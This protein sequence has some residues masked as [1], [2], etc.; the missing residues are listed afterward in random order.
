MFTKKRLHL[1]NHN[2]D[3]NTSIAASDAADEI[4]AIACKDSHLLDIAAAN[5]RSIASQDEKAKAAF[6][7]I[8]EIKHSIREITWINPTT[9][10][11]DLQKI[12]S[13]NSHNISN[14]YK[15]FK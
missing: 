15:C 10:V 6:Y 3:F 1:I 11:E 2:E 5:G 12:F 13:K 14:E 4:K 7:A 9:D 8:P